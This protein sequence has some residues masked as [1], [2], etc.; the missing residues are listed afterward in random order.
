MLEVSQYLELYLW[1]HFSVASSLS[2]LMSIVTMVNEKFKERVPAWEAF[3]KSPEKFP[4]FFQSVLKLTLNPGAL[5]FESQTLLLIFLIHIFNS[6][7]VDMIREQAQKLVSIH[8]WTNLKSGRLNEI[9]KRTPKMKKFMLAIKKQDA[10]LSEEDLR[11]TQFERNFFYKLLKECFCK[12][13]GTVKEK[14][15]GDSDKVHYCERVL[16]LLIDLQAQLPTRRFL[17]T[18]LDD[19]HLVVTC[20]RSLLCKRS[21]LFT[22]LLDMLEFYTGFE[23][24]DLT[25]EPMTSKEMTNTHYKRIRD[26]QK[27]AF[28]D[29]NEELLKF[30]LSN[31]SA[32]DTK[33]SLRKHLAGLSH[34]KL[35][36]LATSLN[37][38]PHVA[39]SEEKGTSED[40]A[41]NH[42]SK[43]FIMDLMVFRFERRVSQLEAIN[44]MPLYPTEQMIWD[45]NLVP[46]DYYS[47]QGCLALPK[48]NLQFLTLHDY[49]LRNFHLFRLESTYEIRQ[50]VEETVYRMKPWQS[51]TGDTL[52][53]GWARMALPI[54]GFN[55]VE[56]AKPRLGENHPARVRA[57]ITILLSPRYNIRHEWESLRKHDVAFLISVNP[58]N[59]SSIR[60]NYK[61]PFIPQVG[62]TYVRGCEIE[63]MLDADGRV[64]EE[65]P[66][67]RPELKGNRRTYR[68]WLDPNQYKQ[69]MTANEE[70]EQD[71]YDS[72]NIIMRR[73]PKEN[74][75]KAVLETIRDLMNT[76]CVVPGWLQD[77]LLGYGDPGSAHYSRMDQ[78]LLTLDWNDTF[79][80]E[81]HLCQSFP[82]KEVQLV[83]AEGSRLPPYK[84]TMPA[85]PE[86]TTL[87]ARCHTVAN[88]GPYDY[89]VPKRSSIRFTSTQIEAIRAGTNHGLTMV[90]G[91]PGTGKTDV[92][93]QIISNLYHN[94]PEQR[95]LIVTHSNQALNQ[96][97]EK[98]MA[99]DIDERHLLRMGHGEEGLETDKDFSRY[100]RVNYV[101][102]QR[103]ELLEEVARLQASL[104][105]EGDV[106]YTCETAAHFFLYQV[107]S[108]WERYSALLDNC[109]LDYI[110]QDFPFH[111][112]F[113][114]APQPLFKGKSKE[115]DLE[116][117]MGCFQHIKRIFAQLDEFRAF[118]LLRSGA[119]RARYLLIKEAKIIAMTC[120]HAALKR[121]DLVAARFQYDNILM[122]ESAQ[123]LEIETFIPLLLQ[124]PED[125]H[126]RLK[127]WIMIGDHHQLPPVIK[128][129][130]FQ[131]YSNM[132]QSLFTR[133]VRLG[134][135]TV[136]LD[137]Q[138]RAR[139]S[140]ANLYRWRYK[141]L[142]DLEHVNQ[143]DQYKT[144]NAGFRFD[145]QL[146]DVQDFNGVGESAPNPYFYQNLAEAEYC[147]A[148]FMYMRLL[149]YPAEKITILT[150]YN[151]QKHLLRDVVAQRCA[152]NPLIG[153]PS[154]I[155]T[156]DRFQGQQNDY[157]L[158]SLV[159][160]KTV[161][162]LRDVRRL[163]VAMSRARLGLY[164]FG[165]VSL[166]QNCVELTP[167]FSQLTERPLKLHLLPTE[168]YPTQRPLE[169]VPAKGEAM[170]V[171]DMQ[172]MTFFVYDM[173]N[174]Q[175]QLM[176]ES[177]A[178]M[179]EPPSSNNEEKKDEIIK[180]D[181]TKITKD[182]EYEILDETVA[183]ETRQEETKPEKSPA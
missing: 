158:L 97:F 73:K 33:S 130:A 91:P 101:L 173:Y 51:E 88:R 79:M 95:T 60:Y 126:N 72:F 136:D 163:V 134:V 102:A 160:T 8:I 47:G 164:V 26:L 178:A 22:Q 172:A 65:G 10:R 99:L 94:F 128:N 168:V 80:D 133:L 93:V 66:D 170:V 125:G 81:E 16:E 44:E 149:G 153:Q 32:V 7:E 54:E 48:L 121:H 17:N 49:L 165:R 175:V 89:S 111:T 103:L 67:P 74:N 167:T 150:T 70:G 106:S 138:G 151:G 179:P 181:S 148:T 50:D 61:E 114:N 53:A 90:V 14:L 82:G 5:S 132:E 169:H 166:F 118:E 135:P 83:D 108:R 124:N 137:A 105:V 4:E 63:G 45:E 162:H 23:I 2:H 129:M 86:E 34:D 42:Y 12:T 27:A 154:K 41:K 59:T 58:S 176:S 37:L 141:R 161:G 64:I 30:A 46:G 19:M 180:E 112:F 87:V 21:K 104:G 119:D 100:G 140:I 145:Y 57:D 38:L 9:L 113:E 24:N 152:N 139:S 78:Q 123:I 75:F 120:T 157:I 62:L 56:V 107:L 76:E 20:R 3:K 18:L 52:F 84:L 171:T 182:I 131:K 98:I 144:A 55:V 143:M 69:D 109:T 117:A 115:E 110:S 142:G 40:N 11:I 68:V 39:N 159:R 116:I 127:R 77:I 156:V 155:T 122:E 146:I 71:V 1:K 35:A 147:V 92:A 6:L 36:L 29:F 85:D 174:S 28:R 13:L 25:G 96:L 183:K 31:V 43:E 177:Q 15:A